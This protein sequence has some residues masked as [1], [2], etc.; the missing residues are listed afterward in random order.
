MVSLFCC[1]EA[2][3][4]VWEVGRGRD[5]EGE[6]LN[7]SNHSDLITTKLTKL[8]LQLKSKCLGGIQEQ[9]LAVNSK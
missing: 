8:N 9:R 6:T 5:V 7:Y 4:R 1:L 2:H 3:K